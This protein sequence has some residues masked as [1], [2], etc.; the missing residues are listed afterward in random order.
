MTAEKRPVRETTISPGPAGSRHRSTVFL[1]ELDRAQDIHSYE[2]TDRPRAVNRVDE[3]SFCGCGWAMI[4][5]L[6]DRYLAAGAFFF[7]RLCGRV[8]P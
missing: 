2:A 1:L 7:L 4:V 3:S 6:L 5:R 8:L